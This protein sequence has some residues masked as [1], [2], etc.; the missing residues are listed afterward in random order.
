MCCLPSA[1]Q[2]L[3]CAR[4]QVM[5]TLRRAPAMLIIGQSAVHERGM[6]VSP[7]FNRLLQ[8]C[9]KAHLHPDASAAKQTTTETT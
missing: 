2:A 3:V 8:H 5:N 1:W 6:N 9:R 4:L 7:H